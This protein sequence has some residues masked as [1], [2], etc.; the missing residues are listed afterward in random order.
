MAIP[1]P[2]RVTLFWMVWGA[3][4]LLAMTLTPARHAWAGAGLTYEN[5]DMLFFVIVIGVFVSYD[6]R[7]FSVLEWLSWTAVVV[8]LCLWLFLWWTPVNE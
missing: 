7:R 3:N 6:L 4:I 5:G 1:L 2:N 8:P